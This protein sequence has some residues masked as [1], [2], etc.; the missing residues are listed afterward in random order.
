MTLGHRGEREARADR[1][2]VNQ[3]GAGAAHTDSTA[4]AHAPQPELVAQQR[5]RVSAHRGRDTGRRIDQHRA[6]NAL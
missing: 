4:L 6:R 3:H 5:D 2:A 1:S